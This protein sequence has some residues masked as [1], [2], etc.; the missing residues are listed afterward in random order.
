[1]CEKKRKNTK[2]KYNRILLS[3]FGQANSMLKLLN[4]THKTK[5]TSLVKQTDD[6]YTLVSVKLM[7][8]EFIQKGNVRI[9]II[10]ICLFFKHT[11]RQIHI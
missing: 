3:V 4:T 6:F 9:S 1:M 7:V 11:D 8:M 5:F 2:E 10:Y